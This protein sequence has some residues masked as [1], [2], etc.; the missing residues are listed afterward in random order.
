M[1]QTPQQRAQEA[2]YWTERIQ[3]MQTALAIL[4]NP[5]PDTAT[6]KL[7]T[8]VKEAQERMGAY[9]SALPEWLPLYMELCKYG[10]QLAEQLYK[11]REAAAAE[12]AQR[13]ERRA[14]RHGHRTRTVTGAAEPAD[15]DS[16]PAEPSAPAEA[17]APERD[18]A[19]ELLAWLRTQREP[20]SISNIKRGLDVSGTTAKQLLAILRGLGTVIVTGTEPRL[21]YSAA[22][23][24]CN[25]SQAAPQSASETDIS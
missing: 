22:E 5:P 24:G 7:Y 20:V 15:V 17:H 12:R 4:Q 10:G 18:R 25:N 14:R 19:Q 3:C 2:A 11:E 6:A 1:Q 16:A 23:G 8:L 13:A 21:F 9:G